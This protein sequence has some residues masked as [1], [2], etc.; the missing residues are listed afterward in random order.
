[1]SGL[2]VAVLVPVLVIELARA[3]RAV[4]EWIAS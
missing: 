3:Y 4:R 1:M 2:L